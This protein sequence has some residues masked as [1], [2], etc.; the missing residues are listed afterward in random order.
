M[1]KEALHKKFNGITGFFMGWIADNNTIFS[2][3]EGD[4]G[5]YEVCIPNKM[6]P[7]TIIVGKSL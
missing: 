7:T 1:I 4:S 5:E 3:K 2:C 6:V